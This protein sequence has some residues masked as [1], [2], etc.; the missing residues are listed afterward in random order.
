MAD[1]TTKKDAPAVNGNKE[2]SK[3]ES[4]VKAPEPLKVEDGQS[5]SPTRLRSRG[6][7]EASVG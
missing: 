7:D 3:P 2:E 4:E 6:R 5:P 1:E